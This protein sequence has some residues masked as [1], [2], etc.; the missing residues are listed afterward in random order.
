VVI[1]GVGLDGPE[2]NL[3][4]AEEKEFAFELWTDDEKVLG[5]TYGALSGDRDSS[6]DRV[7]MLLDAEGDLLLTYTEAINV[8]TH[9]ADVLEDCAAIFGG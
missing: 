7:T 4:W 1:V 2:A 8:G 9:P 3:A 6:V 5:V